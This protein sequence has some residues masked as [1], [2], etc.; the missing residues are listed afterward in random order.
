MSGMC[1]YST[2]W[3]STCHRFLLCNLLILWAPGVL[4]KVCKIRILQALSIA[5]LVFFLQVESC[6]GV[7][8]EKTGRAPS[9]CHE[10]SGHQ[11]MYFSFVCPYSYCGSDCIFA[12]DLF[13]DA[14]ADSNLNRSACS[15][16]N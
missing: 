9:T 7:G 2:F 5:S 15:I 13:S 3:G 1:R 16:K 4:H 10:T 11:H 6:A 8:H 12:L 14:D